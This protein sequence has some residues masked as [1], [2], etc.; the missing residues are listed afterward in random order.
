MTPPADAREQHRPPQRR[1]AADRGNAAEDAFE[2]L[3]RAQQEAAALSAQADISWTAPAGSSAE[4]AVSSGPEVAPT[5]A[6]ST[7]AFVEKMSSGVVPT[8][9]DCERHITTVTM[10]WLLAVGRALQAIREHELFKEKGYTSFTA[11][12]KAEH[13]WHPSYVS[14]VIADIPVVEALAE[15]GVDRDVN[16]GQATA[17]RPV[18]EEYG[19]EALYEVWDSTQ[20]K[21]SAAAL[22]RVARAKGYLPA[23]EDAGELAQEGS[24]YSRNLSRF[25]EFAMLVTDGE[26]KRLIEAAKEDPAW[27]KDV[28]FPALQQAVWVLESEFGNNG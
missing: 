18:L 4:V 24:V 5:A 6:A 20:G 7:D 22:V 17:V 8:L 15:H 2:R 26:G 21:K 23:E 9:E 13:P 28:L 14:R 1:R 19:R 11:Y 10:Q 25:R 27:G 12:I 3:E 16:E